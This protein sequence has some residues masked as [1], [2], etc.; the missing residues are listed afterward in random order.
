MTRA[1]KVIGRLVSGVLLASLL[2]ACGSAVSVGSSSSASTAPPPTPTLIGTFTDAP[3]AGLF[4]TTNSGSG[5]CTPSAPCVSDS[6]GQFKYAQGDTVNFFA[7]GIYLGSASPIVAADGSTTV[8]P[9]SL[10]PAATSVTDPTVTTIASLLSTLNAV[11]VATGNG[12]SGVYVIP[13]NDALVAQLST[14]GTLTAANLQTAITA[15]Y[16]ALGIAVPS[17]ATVQAALLQGINAQGVIG[18]VWSG[19]CTCGGGGEFYFQPNGNLVGITQDGATLS[20]SWSGLSSGGVSLSLVSSNGASTQGGAIPTGSSIGAAQVYSSNLA[21]Q[22]TYNFTKVISAAALGNTL[23]LGGWYA[24]FSPNAAGIAS[25]YGSGGSA[26]VIAAPD[27]NLYGLSNDGSYFSG[28]WNPATGAGTAGVMTPAN[29][30]AISVDL[31]SGTGSVTN[32]GQAMGSLAF[33]RTGSFSVT[34]GT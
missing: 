32:N 5:G 33:S 13:N 17:A 18:T 25:G 10:V 7:A 4:Y 16:P 29:P 11:S 3:V 28:T 31:A 6:M 19:S 20:G 23:Y 21:L 34:P 30:K 27:G 26:Y 8:T 15:L 1:S 2:A 22:G 14:V 12:A 9:V 24:S